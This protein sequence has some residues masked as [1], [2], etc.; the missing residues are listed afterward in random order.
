MNALVLAPNRHQIL[1]E[2]LAQRAT[3]C[4]S[5]AHFRLYALEQPGTP[6]T[7][8]A[9]HS[10][11]SE[12]V[13]VHNFAAA[14]IDNNIGY[15]VA[16]ELLPLLDSNQQA[17]FEHLVGAIVRSIHG[18]EQYAWHLFYANSLAAL[19]QAMVQPEAV[20]DF[21]WPFGAIY[22]RAMSLVRGETLLDAGTCF[23]FFPLLLAESETRMRR[24]DEATRPEG[25][26]PCSNDFSRYGGDET[27]GRRGDEATRRR[28]KEAS[29]I[30]ASSHPRIP[31]SRIRRIV[32]CDL[33]PALIKLAGTYAARQE[34]DQVSFVVTDILAEDFARLGTFDTVT[35]MHV[36]E[37]LPSEQTVPALT[38]LWQRTRQRLIIGV[39]LEATPDPRFG[40]MQV[41]D[42]ERLLELGRGMDADCQ[43]FEFHGGWLVLNVK[44]GSGEAFKRSSV[45][46][47]KL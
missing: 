27:R 40:H 17:D 46:A 37:H 20:P 8:P 12:V 45:R 4:A 10:G 44:R 38:S 9:T 14:E 11:S 13:I 16:N 23:G 25:E 18:N 5:S 43:Y 15:Y 30:P 6:E 41:F 19:Q 2:C 7:N 39:P 24:G 21:I 42:R 1:I 36:L 32:G 31:A 26:G 34:L 28:G 47:L 35:C 22:E 33:D 29:R 3:V